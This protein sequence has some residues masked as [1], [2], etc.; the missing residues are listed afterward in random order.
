VDSAYAYLP[1]DASHEQGGALRSKAEREAETGGASRL[2]AGRHAMCGILSVLGVGD[3]S[4]A[5]RSRII[6]LSRR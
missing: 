4:L 2:P 5:K 6:E 1:S 3:V